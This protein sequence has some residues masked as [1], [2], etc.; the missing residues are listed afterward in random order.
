MPPGSCDYGKIDDGCL[1]VI[2]LIGY[3]FD[4]RAAN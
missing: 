1:V 3:N 2:Q 4:K